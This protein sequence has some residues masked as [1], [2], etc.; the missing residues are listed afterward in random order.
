MLAQNIFIFT[1]ASSGGGIYTADLYFQ[2]PSIPQYVNL[3]D[4]IQD[5][6][7][8]EYEIIAPS[9]IPFSEGGTATLQYITSDVLPVGDTDYNSTIYT[10]GQVDVRP[11][12]QTAGSLATPSLYDATNYEYNVLA[13]W[14]DPGEAAK[15]D[16]GD[17]V[18]D[19][20]GKEFE[21]TYID[22]SNRF[23]VL[24]RVKEVHKEA[25]EPLVGEATMY[26]STPNSDFFQGTEM[27]DPPRNVVQ[28]R[29]RFSYDIKFKELEDAIAAG[30]SGSVTESAVTNN[31]GGTLLALTPV[32]S[33]S[34]KGMDSVD[35]AIEA[36]IKAILGVL[37]AD[38]NNGV[39]GT[40][41]NNGRIENITTGIA[42][43]TSVYLSKSG[44]IT[45]TP[46][47]IGVG[48]FLAG[49]FVILLGVITTNE[50]NPSNKD[51]VVNIQLIG[52][53]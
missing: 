51:F 18:V 20:G 29:D 34:V 36:E 4:Y 43:D 5:T 22:P 23:N 6:A 39:Q 11:P 44:G 9:S 31:S 15:A 38:T 26:T 8:N 45:S 10:P 33:D 30:G 50:S 24:C 27:Q 53:L 21:I 42:V 25:Q 41:V 28:N 17:R 7:G 47:D 35:V 16:V 19:S 14:T 13:G 49:D 52:Q 12:M 3:G 1:P 32:R 2:D 46:P 40:I 48:G 37:K